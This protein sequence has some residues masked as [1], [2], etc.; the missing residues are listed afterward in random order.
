MIVRI[1]ASGKSFKGAAEYLTHDPEAAKTADRVGWTHT[2]NLA[3][4]HIPSAVDEMLWTA[5]DA[6]L[7]KQEA[8]I[9]AGGRATEN[10][11][12]HASLNWA[13]ADNPTREHM[14]ETAEEFL[15]HMKWDGHQTV[16]VSHTDKEYA[17]VHLLINAIHPETGL[18][19]DE[20]FEQRRASAWALGYERE[21]GAI[22]C[23]SRLKDEREREEGPTRPA[24]MAFKG[25]EKTFLENEKI[26]AAQ[27]VDFSVEPE[28]PE[29]RQKKE[30]EKLKE[31][32]RDE[33]LAFFAEG[34]SAFNEL[35]TGIYR[36]VRE[37][38]REGWADYYAAAKN[39]DTDPAVL[40]DM[41]A[42]LVS[43]Q[44]AVLEE[45]RDLA[46]KELRESRDG[47]YQELLTG[48]R[49]LRLGLH[50]RQAAGLDS[51]DV[52]DHFT[53]DKL[54]RANGVSSDRRENDV[55]V[56]ERADP[57]YEAELTEE[58]PSFNSEKSGHN[59]RP[60]GAITSN[61]GIG[62]GIGLVSL[63]GGIADGFCAAKPA[64]KA[65]RDLFAVAAVEARDKAARDDEEFEERKR[66]NE[67]ESPQP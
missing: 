1:H 62:V 51:L 41:K 20:G 60:A 50:T 37:E 38:F 66:R 35:R 29:N 18:K 2:L 46:C 5:R 32:Q 40:K 63:L 52:I 31:I 43:Q 12:K 64:P 39:G 10:P 48:Q 30:W 7:L 56:S 9:R 57:T 17:H 59:L 26:L 24:W 23:L 16:I 54:G 4:D 61:V 28:N 42:I 58:A 45:R 55:A 47:Q 27:E 67:R 25:A 14:V 53:V 15:T 49:D 33:R 36:E 19:L 13:I 11:V 3:H 44:N 6:E 65:E 8:G 21:M 34:K 22:H